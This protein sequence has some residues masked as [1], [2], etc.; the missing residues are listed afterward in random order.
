MS[1]SALPSKAIQTQRLYL[2]LA[3]GILTSWTSHAQPAKPRSITRKPPQPIQIRQ[4]P[5][6]NFPTGQQTLRA[7]WESIMSAYPMRMTALVYPNS[8]FFW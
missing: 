4:I 5:Q 7:T 2:I 3:V 8:P 1:G 6:P